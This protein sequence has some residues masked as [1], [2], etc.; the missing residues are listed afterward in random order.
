MYYHNVVRIV[1]HTRYP[2]T[3]ERI[4]TLSGARPIIM[5]IREEDA[6][7]FKAYNNNNRATTKLVI[8]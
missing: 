1:C 4:A 8:M 2:S 6:P 3:G 5:P 7:L